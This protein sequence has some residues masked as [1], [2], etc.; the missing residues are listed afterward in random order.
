M[1][2]GRCAV[3]LK[4]NSDQA[5]HCGMML[6][7]IYMNG[8]I[9]FWLQRCGPQG[10]V[11]KLTQIQPLEKRNLMSRNVSEKFDPVGVQ[12]LNFDTLSVVFWLVLL[13]DG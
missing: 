5:R 6:F 10:V 11:K 7:S 3:T 2:L 12:G 9:E 8:G 4:P 1:A 13:R